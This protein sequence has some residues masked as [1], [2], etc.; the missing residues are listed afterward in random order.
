MRR[1]LVLVPLLV[2]TSA[3]TQNSGNSGAPGGKAQPDASAPT[4]NAESGI[5]LTAEADVPMQIGN[6]VQK[7]I[8]VGS[9]VEALCFHKAPVGYPG[10]V[11]KVRSDET[12]GFVIVGE[13]GDANFDVPVSDLRARLP[14]CGPTGLF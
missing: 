5:N 8:R 14:G 4:S 1:A 6:V 13:D 2:L 10:P 11:A 9:T 7:V 3:C 12:V